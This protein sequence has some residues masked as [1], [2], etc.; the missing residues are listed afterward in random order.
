MRDGLVGGQTHGLA[1]GREVVLN[2]REGGVMRESEYAVARVVPVGA[3]DLESLCSWNRGEFP[4]N[5]IRDD[6]WEYSISRRGRGTMEANNEANGLW[7]AGGCLFRCA[8]GLG[9]LLRGLSG[10]SGI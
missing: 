6:L 7:W 10:S 5:V 1:N 4:V 3:N 9:N 2:E 8:G